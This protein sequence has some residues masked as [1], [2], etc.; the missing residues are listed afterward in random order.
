VQ[1]IYDQL[2]AICHAHGIAQ[3]IHW[4]APL[5]GRAY[6]ELGDTERG[7]RVIE[8]G[9]SAHTSTRSALLRPFYFVLFAGA[10]LRSGLLDRAQAA[11]DESSKVA[12]ATGQFAFLAEHARVQAEV[13]A[14]RGSG[15]HAERAYQES[16][17][18]ARRQGARWFELRTARAYSTFLIAHNRGAEARDVLAPIVAWFTEGRDTLDF[19]YADALLKTLE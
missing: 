13:H 16:L 6:I 12:E 3:E 11:L 18:H 14:A 5:C 8:E 1:R 7:L 17:A 19:V 10:L 9:L 4:A 15:A 2:A